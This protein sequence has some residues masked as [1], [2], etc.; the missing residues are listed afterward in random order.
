MT[1]IIRVDSNEEETETNV[2]FSLTQDDQ[3]RDENKEN[4]GMTHLEDGEEDDDEDED[5]S[6]ILGRTP[7]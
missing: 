3:T 6:L 7:E 1:P 5:G 2:E 4:E